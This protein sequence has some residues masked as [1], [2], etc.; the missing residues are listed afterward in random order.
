MIFYI[1][2]FLIILAIIIW[3]GVTQWEFVNGKGKEGY[4][5]DI[6][7]YENAKKHIGTLSLYK[8]AMALNLKLEVL[9]DDRI[10]IY[11]ENKKLTYKHG[12]IKL[13]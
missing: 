8:A 5:K 13:Y 6:G 3:G 12:T 9:K 7:N 4:E 1:I 2:L 10:N 11:F